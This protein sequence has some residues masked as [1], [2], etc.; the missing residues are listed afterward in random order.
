M[1]N[2]SHEVRTP[3]AGILGMVRVLES[4]GVSDVQRDYL[5]TV[6]N[7][8]LN[9]LGIINDILDLSKIESGHMGTS[10]NRTSQ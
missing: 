4:S 10:N 6:K 5:D 1:A 2:F 9:L 7:C 3:L 8:G